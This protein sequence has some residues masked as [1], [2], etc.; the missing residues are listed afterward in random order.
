[1]YSLTYL[2][3]FPKFLLY[4]I[5]FSIPILITFNRYFYMLSIILI[6][7]ACARVELTI[8][9]EKLQFTV[10]LFGRVIYKRTIHPNAILLMKFRREDWAQKA[11]T[12]KMKKGPALRFSNVN[13]DEFFADMICYARQYEI[14]IL[15]TNDYKIIERMRERR[16][17]NQMGV[18]LNENKEG[19]DS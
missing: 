12:I 16:R 8:E 19:N 9:G 4:L 1:M 11:I 15:K 10:S 17:K 6:V 5:A 13:R 14:P 7:L 2:T 3:I 18:S